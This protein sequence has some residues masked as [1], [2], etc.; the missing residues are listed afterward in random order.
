MKLTIEGNT[1]KKSQMFH[2][3]IDQENSNSY[4]VWKRMGSPQNP[5]PQQ[6]AELEKAGMLKM[7]QGPEN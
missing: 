6:Y 2:Y 5:T 3:R 4:T 1:R 7:I